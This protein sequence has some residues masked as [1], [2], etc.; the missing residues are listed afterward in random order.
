M[1]FVLDSKDW[2]SAWTFQ[3]PIAN[4][5]E[6]SQ[7]KSYNF[8]NFYSPLHRLQCVSCIVCER[9]QTSRRESV[10]QRHLSAFIF[11]HLEMMIHLRD[12]GLE[13]ARTP[14]HIFA[15]CTNS[16]V[17]QRYVNF[18]EKN[19]IFLLV[20][21]NANKQYWYCVTIGHFCCCGGAFSIPMRHV[22]TA[23]SHQSRDLQ[24][25][26]LTCC[27]VPPSPST[28][29]FIHILFQSVQ[30]RFGWMLIVAA[31]KLP[32]HM[33]LFHKRLQFQIYLFSKRIKHKMRT[34]FKRDRLPWRVRSCFKNECEWKREKLFD[35]LSLCDVPILHWR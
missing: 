1:V 14:A 23:N 18:H 3:E 31:T 35:L 10:R 7:L 21:S 29:S 25:N 15:N 2:I 27:A 24:V 5:R 17:H 26:C 8:E 11:N 16:V 6:F 33:K 4:D 13:S 34:S 19:C 22:H 30:M 28:I 9:T 12:D 20:N 32:T